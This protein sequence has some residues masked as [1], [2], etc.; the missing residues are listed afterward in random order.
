[1]TL[2]P[3]APAKGRRKTLNDLADLAAAGGSEGRAVQKEAAGPLVA[4]LAEGTMPEED[5]L[6]AALVLA[7]VGAEVPLRDALADTTAPVVVRR[8]TAE[9]LGLL[10]KRSGDREQRDRIAA[11]LEG[12]L[13]SDAL[14]VVIEP[15][16]D[17]AV[18]AVAQEAA[19][20]QVAAKVAEAR[21]GGQL[22]KI[23]EAQLL[24]MIRQIEEQAAQQELWAIGASPGWAEHDAR[25]PLLACNWRR[26]R[27]CPC[28]AAARV[29][30]CRCSR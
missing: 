22:E 3:E 14:D 6:D 21:A 11:E 15:V 30:R 16:N 10:A 17:P 12:W 26:P 8:R 19:Q 20:R 27:I 13:R 28:L 18:V 9:S 1:V 7:L 23:K 2:T 5:R 29:A 24:Q 25:L 4:L